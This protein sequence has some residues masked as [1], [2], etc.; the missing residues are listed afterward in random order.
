MTAGRFYHPEPAAGPAELSG[1]EAHHALHVLRVRVGEAVELFDGKGKAAAARITGVSRAVVYLECDPP[2]L[3][4]RPAPLVHLASAVPKGNRMDWLLEKITE[5]GAASFTPV[6]F[7]RTV[8]GA[9]EL[10]PAKR[11]R[12]FGHCVSAAK[13]CGLN[14]LLELGEPCELKAA[15]VPSRGL[16]LLGDPEGAPFAQAARPPADEVRILVGPEGGLTQAEHRLV[17]DA[18]FV[19]ARLGATVLRVET[20]AVALVAAAIACR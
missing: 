1:P 12:W 4:P 8:G 10:S 2:R 20:A 19:P 14:H 5:L 15:L 18:G 13:Q 11:Q 17:T 16:R 6:V 9:S 7:E 3:T